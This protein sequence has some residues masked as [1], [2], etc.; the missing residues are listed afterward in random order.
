MSNNW[1]DDARILDQLCLDARVADFPRGANRARINLL[2]NG[3][4]PYTEDEVQKNGVAI[5]VNSLELTSLSHAG[6]MQFLQG[7]VKPGKYFSAQ[8]DF[9]PVHDRTRRSQIVTKEINRILKNSINYYE[10]IRGQFALLV[11]HG[12]SPSIW[13]DKHRML[14]RVI[15]IDDCF[16]PAG[17]L[18][19]FE[20]LSRVILY[21][22]FT[23]MELQTLVYGT[24]EP[25]PGWNVPMV[26]RVMKWVDSKASQMF[27]S[28]YPEM[29]SPEKQSERMK[30]HNGYYTS[31]RLPTVDC[32]DIYAYVDDGKNSGWVR[33]IILDTWGTPSNAGVG[34]AQ[35]T[36]RGDM[37]DLTKLT[38]GDF[39]YNSKKR[40]VAQNLGNFATWQFADLSAVAPFR[41]HSVRSLGYL[42]YALCHIQNRLRCSFMEAVFENLM[43]IMK[44]KNM[45]EVQ[46]VLSITLANRKFIDDSFSFVPPQERWQ[47]N[48]QLAQLGL[49]E[50]DKLIKSH[51]GTM[52]PQIDFKD[53]TE[54]TK[55]QVMAELNVTQALVGA[56]LQQAYMYKKFEYIEIFRRGCRPDSKDARVREFQ[57][58]CVRQNVPMSALN[59][60]LW[61][62]ESERIMGDGNKTMELAI[63]EQLMQWRPMYDQPSQRLILREATAALVNDPAKAELYVPQ[64]PQI[65]SSVNKAQSDSGALMQ[66][67]PVGPIPG[68]NEVEYVGTLLQVMTFVIQ[69]ATSQQTIPTPEQLAGLRNMAATAKEHMELMAGDESIREV[70]SDYNKKLTFISMSI[71]KAEQE[72]MK[73]AMEAQQQAGEMNGNGGVDPKDL[74]KIQGDKIKAEAKADNMRQSHAQRTAQK[75]VQFE[76]TLEQ[77]RTRTAAEIER[78]NVRTAADIENERIRAENAPKKE[79][80]E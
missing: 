48:Y 20:N 47:V 25:D 3:S 2:A 78:E 23:G 76:Q 54:K 77:D 72:H 74:S 35:P 68:I 34:V 66:G 69:K 9:G 80:P 10:T 38:K 63:A 73:Q 67:L 49:Q 42:L 15:G 41:Y 79:K 65:S 19:G 45:D 39:L 12:I 56:A 52:T 4:P 37:G 21:R 46:R 40:R 57:A 1:F 16:V 70:F 8:T 50:N 75:Q 13:E 60:S 53:R 27:N 30:G 7:F 18:V 14:P 61:E 32:F 64:E 44:V 33:R 51:A 62:I 22:S 5:N 59:P 6:R 29:W 11:L 36:R 55:F 43:M 31:D 28:N 26:D 71:Q 24:S 58:R 17:S